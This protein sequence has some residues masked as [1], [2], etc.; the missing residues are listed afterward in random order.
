VPTAPPA[1]T[2]PQS[3]AGIQDTRHHPGCNFLFD[4]GFAATITPAVEEEIKRY[5]A[6]ILKFSTAMNLTAVK[7]ARAFERKFVLPSLA[8]CEWLPAEG[9]LLDVGSGMGIP[10]IPILLARRRL[11]GALVE[12]RQKRAEFLRHIVRVLALRADVQDCD[13]RAL[14]GIQADACVARAVANPEKLLPMVSPHMRTGAVAVLPVARNAP[15]AGIH[16]WRFEGLEVVG[17]GREKQYVQRYRW[18]EVS[19]ET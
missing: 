1:G 9:V 18:M 4:D 8:L 5:I 2:A 13:I 15:S 11:R 7:E 16:G 19:R 12:R 17:T 14:S 3:G 6:E 10:A